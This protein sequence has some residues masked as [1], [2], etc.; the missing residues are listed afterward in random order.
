MNLVVARCTSMVLPP[1]RFRTT[2]APMPPLTGHWRSRTSSTV[3]LK[4]A[5]VAGSYL[6]TP[7]WEPA[8]GAAKA[9]VKMRATASVR[10]TASQI[11]MESLL[12]ESDTWALATKFI[13]GGYCPAGCDGGHGDE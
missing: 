12:P 4:T 9:G 5:S 6:G 8:L 10:M 2:C 7:A 1:P 3:P 13:M 11:F